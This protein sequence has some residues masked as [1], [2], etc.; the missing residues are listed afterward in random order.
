[1]IAKNSSFTTRIKCVILNK[2]LWKD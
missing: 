1:M 2:N